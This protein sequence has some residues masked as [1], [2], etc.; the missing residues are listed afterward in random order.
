MAID[1]F[2]QTIAVNLRGT[3]DLIRQILPHLARNTPL[4][5]DGERGII[6]NVSSI[7]AYDGQ[8]GQ[9]AYAASKGAIASLTLPLA[10][11]LAEFGVR[12]VT[13][14]PGPFESG[15]TAMMSDKVNK[16]LEK[17]MEFPKRFGKPEEF[18][19]LVKECIENSMLNGTVIRLD[20]A[21]RM[22]S[23]L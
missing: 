2:D 16:S 13:L 14:A 15:M 20:G 18:A 22:P 23:K 21:L 5:P 9:I 12:A 11:D 17:T 10:R 6:I 19:S 7:A 1:V 8:I 4:P 3:V